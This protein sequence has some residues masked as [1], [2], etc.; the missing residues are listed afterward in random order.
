MKTKVRTSQSSK[1]LVLLQCDQWSSHAMRPSFQI[2]IT[3]NQC[4]STLVPLK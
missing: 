3:Q 4:I 1:C 2:G